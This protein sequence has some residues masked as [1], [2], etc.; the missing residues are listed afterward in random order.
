[1]LL[2]IKQLS[3]KLNVKESWIRQHIFRGNIPVTKIGRLVRFNES[4]IDKWLEK[5]S[6][7]ENDN[8]RS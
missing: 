3:K 6:E 1:M 5:N 7:K 2:T 4:K 8:G